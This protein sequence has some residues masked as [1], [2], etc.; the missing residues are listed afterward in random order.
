MTR[1]A[2]SPRIPGLYEKDDGPGPG[3]RYLASRCGSLK[4][5]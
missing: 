3:S 2:S 1:P 5:V 4:V